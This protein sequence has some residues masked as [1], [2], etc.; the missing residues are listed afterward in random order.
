MYIISLKDQEHFQWKKKKKRE[1]KG[2][3]HKQGQK[4]E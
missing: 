3:I 2:G 1:R 4:P